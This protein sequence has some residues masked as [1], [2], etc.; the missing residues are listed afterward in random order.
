MLKVG[1]VHVLQQLLTLVPRPASVVRMRAPPMRAHAGLLASR[2][3][4]RLS[5]AAPSL[6]TSAVPSAAAACNY[7]ASAALQRAGLGWDV[8]SKG[9]GRA[10]WLSPVAASNCKF[11]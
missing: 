1:F 9:G 3:N 8:L 10:A 2:P 5:V 7:T 4:P 6:P 11:C